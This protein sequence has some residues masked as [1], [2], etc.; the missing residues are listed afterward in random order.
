MGWCELFVILAKESST[1]HPPPEGEGGGGYEPGYCQYTATLNA[2]K[3][4]NRSSTNIGL[5]G[6]M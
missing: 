1:T 5:E 3:T 2:M 6:K 4:R